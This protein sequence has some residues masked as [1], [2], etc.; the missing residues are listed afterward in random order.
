MFTGIGLS[1]LHETIWLKF[2]YCIANN[3]T[4]NISSVSGI[5]NFILDNTVIGLHIE[6][7]C[8][9]VNDVFKIELKN[10]AGG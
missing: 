4:N 9:F 6:H 5:A 3:Y 1:I 10:F 7:S 8:R 2:A